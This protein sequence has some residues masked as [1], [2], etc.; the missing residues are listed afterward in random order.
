V[1]LYFALFQ[2]KRFIVRVAGGS[3]LEQD[4]DDELVFES[5]EVVKGVI[6]FHHLSTNLYIYHTIVIVVNSKT[7][8]QMFNLKQ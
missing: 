8:D 1:F 7:R 6:K 3:A 2:K 5:A 4:D